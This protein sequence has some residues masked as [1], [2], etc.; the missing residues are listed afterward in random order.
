ML[1]FAVLP[2]RRLIDIS[3]SSYY[4]Y[5]II[6]QVFLRKKNK[7]TCILIG[8]VIFLLGL[9]STKNVSNTSTE[10]AFDL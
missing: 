10:M 8:L 9:F 5:L 1:A 7:K 6:S 3:S 2:A 4:G